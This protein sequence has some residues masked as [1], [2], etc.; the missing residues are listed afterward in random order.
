MQ[1]QYWYVLKT[2]PGVW[3]TINDAEAGVLPDPWQEPPAI[4]DLLAEGQEADEEGVAAA[5]SI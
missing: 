2:K 3:Q 5:E 4:F 1:L